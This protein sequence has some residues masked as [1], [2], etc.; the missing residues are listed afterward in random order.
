MEAA[1]ETIR[2]LPQA[3]AAHFKNEIYHTIYMITKYMSAECVWSK[4]SAYNLSLNED[5][6][7]VLQ[8]AK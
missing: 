2:R 5:N 8:K 1:E 4:E 7:Y 3:I 6:V